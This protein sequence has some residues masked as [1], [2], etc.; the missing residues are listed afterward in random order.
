MKNSDKNQ[1]PS[2]EEYVSAKKNVIKDIKGIKDKLLESYSDKDKDAVVRDLAAALYF[3]MS[4]DKL[5]E[6]SM[7]LGFIE[8][9]E[10]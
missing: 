6:Y 1:E 8:D 2:K 7:L 3:I 9:K 4:M 5:D 10:V